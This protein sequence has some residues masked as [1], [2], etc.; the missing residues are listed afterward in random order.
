MSEYDAP[1]IT[2]SHAPEQRR[3]KPRLKKRRTLIV[4]LPLMVLA[5]IST[6]FGMMMA[7]A[8]DLP[9]LEQIPQTSD[10]KNSVM[11]DIHGKKLG[12]LTSN[13]GRIIA[14]KDDIGA[15]VKY[16]V[17]ATEDERFYENSG[18]DLKGI[19]RAFAQDIVSGG[20]A[21]QGGSTITQQFVKVA[22]K[23]QDQR[24]VFNKLRESAL[25]YHLTH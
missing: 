11:Y 12:T 23:N 13:E 1:D 2:P 20:Q 14:S 15:Y 8:S 9:A 18:V 17:I 7:V 21:V 6:V 25:A 3:P 22:A 10:S 24:T 4:V 5:L 16:A 19:G